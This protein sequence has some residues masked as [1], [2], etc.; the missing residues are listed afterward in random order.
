M[1]VKM[2]RS[3]EFEQT[4]YLG[5]GDD[6]GYQR[7]KVKLEV[8]SHYELTGEALV[9]LAAIVDMCKDLADHLAPEYRLP[10]FTYSGSITTAASGGAT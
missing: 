7:P 3:G 1:E 4:F 9:K 2:E 10:K 5:D 8:E 6:R